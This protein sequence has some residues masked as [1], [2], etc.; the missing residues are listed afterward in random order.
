MSS[1]PET[2][3]DFGTRLGLVF[4]IE[5]AFLSA[6][7]VTWVLLYI[8]VCGLFHVAASSLDIYTLVQCGKNQTWGFSKMV[9]KDAYS[10]VFPESHDF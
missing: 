5:A 4:I 3:F 7:A 2:P 6:L 10:L 8:G 9:D 1:T